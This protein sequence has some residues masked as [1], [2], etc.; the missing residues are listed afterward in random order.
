MPVCRGP[1]PCLVVPVPVPDHDHAPGR[2]DEVMAA[3]VRVP[4]GVVEAAL[5]SLTTERL[6][7]LWTVA[8]ALGH[9]EVRDVVH[10][11]GEAAKLTVVAGRRVEVQS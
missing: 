11:M 8:V 2:G 4:I 10:R 7:P 6:P 9:V 1:C 5:R 3:R